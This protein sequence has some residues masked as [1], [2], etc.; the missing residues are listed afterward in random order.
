MIVR[1]KVGRPSKYTKALADKICFLI[2]EGYSERKICAIEGMP[3]VTTLSRWKDAHPEFC[4][5]SARARE[6]S[7]ISNRTQTV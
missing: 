5:R 1:K 6:A 4:Q 3:D 2:E 7:K